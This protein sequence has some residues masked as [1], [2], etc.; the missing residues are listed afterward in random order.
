MKEILTYLNIIEND[1]YKYKKYIPKFDKITKDMKININTHQGQKQFGKACSF[2]VNN[3]KNNKVLK[4]ERTRYYIFFVLKILVV[5]FLLFL[6]IVN[7]LNIQT[8]SKLI[9]KIASDTET[10]L[11]L[12][13]GVIFIYFFFPIFPKPIISETDVKL[14]FSAGISLLLIGIMRFFKLDEEKKEE[15]ELLKQSQENKKEAEEL[16]EILKKSQQDKQHAEELLK[17]SQENKK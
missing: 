5:S 8:N 16:L 17:Q 1:K 14:A 6:I 10:F 2:Y 12:F 9:K 11:F 13:L 3:K 4:Y 15:E 7:I